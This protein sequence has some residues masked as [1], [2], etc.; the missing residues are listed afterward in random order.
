MG[1]PLRYVI[2]PMPRMPKRGITLAWTR[3][4]VF[5]LGGR[6]GDLQAL[7]TGNPERILKRVGN[8]VIGR[9][10]TRKIQLKTTK[11]KRK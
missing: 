9:N 3:S 5:W 6:L 4:M 2:P 8:K 11:R 1:N 10:V 7:S